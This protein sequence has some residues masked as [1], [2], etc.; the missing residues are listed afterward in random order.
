VTTEDH[1][2]RSDS[3]EDHTRALNAGIDDPPKEWRRPRGRPRQTWLCTVENDLKQQNLRLWSARRRAYDWEQWC[4]IVE[5]A[6][7]LQGHAMSWWWWWWW[8]WWWPPKRWIEG[9]LRR[10]A[11]CME[12][13]ENN[14]KTEH[15]IEWHCIEDR[16]QRELIAASVTMKSWTDLIESTKIT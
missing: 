16:E 8:W 14:S 3:D 6:T 10:A 9:N 11:L 13:C 4:D 12:V 15:D 2:V 5:T 1:V 7:L